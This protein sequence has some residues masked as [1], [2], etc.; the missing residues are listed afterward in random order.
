MVETAARPNRALLLKLA[1]VAAVVLVGAVLLARG[2]NVMALVQQG[3]GLIRSAGPV[4]FFLAMLLLPAVGAPLSF[5]SL[6]A[7]SVF[8]PQLGLPLVMVLSLSAIALNMALSYV[9]ASRAFRPVLEALVK[10]LGYRL[11]QVDSGDVTDLIV[12]LRV[13]PG[14]PFPAQNYLLGLAGVPFVRYLVVSCLIQLPIN[15]AVIFFG[16]ALLHGKGKIA[17][18]SLLLLLALMTGAH[19]V[20]KHYGAK[21]KS[22]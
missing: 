16:E 4:T 17:L 15:G 5:F 1:I 20:R 10:R 2:Y 7:G 3:L 21:R 18:V 8:G 22:P 12:L 11:P 19:L 13:T 6:T 14:V 9:L